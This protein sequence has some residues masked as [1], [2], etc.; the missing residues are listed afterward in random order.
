[1]P[2]TFTI[3][4]HEHHLASATARTTVMREAVT[5]LGAVVFPARTGVHTDLRLQFTMQRVTLHT[6]HQRGHETP[7]TLH[8]DLLGLDSVRYKYNVQQI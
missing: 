3:S 6:M 2:Q 8:V 5:A 4:F 1:M 7:H